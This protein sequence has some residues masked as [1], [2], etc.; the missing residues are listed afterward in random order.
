MIAE[1]L[2]ENLLRQK[3]NVMEAA[4]HSNRILFVDTDAVTTLFYSHFLLG[5]KQKELTVCT[6]LAEAIHETDRWDLVLFLEPD[7]EFIQDGT[8]N[9]KIRQDREGC[10]LRIKELLDRYRGGVPLYR[11]HISGAFQPC[12]GT[13]TGTNRTG[14]SVVTSGRGTQKCMK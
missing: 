13:D 14:H 6:K 5:D 4:K 10:S 12:K 3:I 11:R 1:D 7:V 8:R 2:Y 9:E